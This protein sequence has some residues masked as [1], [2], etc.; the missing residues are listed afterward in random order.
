M[1]LE[2]KEQLAIEKIEN[3]IRDKKEV[4]KKEIILATKLH[5]NY[6]DRILKLL[7]VEGKIMTARVESFCG[8]KKITQSYRIKWVGE[9]STNSPQ[10]DNLIK[11][12]NQSDIEVKENGNNTI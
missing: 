2:T 3:F 10:T 7:E 1:S 5:S 4:G 12:D 11:N 9:N 6:I 8:N